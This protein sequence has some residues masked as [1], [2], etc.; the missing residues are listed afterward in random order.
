MHGI[1]CQCAILRRKAVAAYTFSELLGAMVSAMR[2]NRLMN[3]KGTSFYSIERPKC[4]GDISSRLV[5]HLTLPGIS[6]S[7]AI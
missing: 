5:L 4:H 7:L 3:I 2:T 1:V 6:P